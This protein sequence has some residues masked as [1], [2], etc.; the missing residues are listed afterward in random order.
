LI[1]NN[2]DL[3]VF[4]LKLSFFFFLFFSFLLNNYHLVIKT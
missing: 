2:N 1:Y 4:L 3:Y